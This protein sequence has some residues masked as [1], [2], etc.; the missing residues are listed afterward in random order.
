[1]LSSKIMK[2]IYN[3][4]VCLAGLG[5]VVLLLGGCAGPA[6][7]TSFND[8]AGVYA[9]VS[10][11]QMLLNLARLSN[12]HPTYFLQMGG[13]NTTYQFVASAGTNTVKARNESFVGAPI[14]PILDAI[15]FGAN[16]GGSRNEQPSFN[17]TPLAGGIF[18]QAVLVPISP[19]VLFALYEQGYRVDHLLRTLVQSIELI[20][21]EAGTSQIF[22]NTP[23]EETPKNFSDFLT[24]CGVARELQKRNL[25]IISTQTSL[26]PVPSPLFENLKLEDI[27]KAGA[28]GMVLKEVAPSKYGLSQT[29]SSTAFKLDPM[30]QVVMQKLGDADVTFRLEGHGVV[31]SAE[32]K[33]SGMV[34]RLR[35]F[36]SILQAVATEAAIFD[37]IVAADP[38][39]LSNLPSTQRQPILRLK[40]DNIASTERLPPL[41]E[42]D[43]A[44]SRYMISDF[45]PTHP[46]KSYNRN[47]F[48]LLNF[49]FSQV[50]MDSSK[51]P[52][53]QLIQLK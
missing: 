45:V 32:G 49:L 23:D 42:L 3:A 13:I 20:D 34:I 11:R 43:Y 27:L 38:G 51:L 33:Q 48:M 7:R 14:I 5:V 24:L 21:S 41:T 46:Q 28:Q 44:G 50:A 8:Y 1:M 35:P 4:V 37:A 29:A 15:S 31:S 53:P 30:A 10:N 36:I 2:T 19:N 6:L 26:S 22:I 52:T 18:A 12:S 16:I 40:W 25:L 9:E 47:I 39:F 17:F